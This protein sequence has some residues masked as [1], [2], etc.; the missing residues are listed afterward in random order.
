MAGRSRLAVPSSHSRA[1]ALVTPERWRQIT[2]IFHA[3]LA[4]GTRKRR[5]DF[6]R[7]VSPADPELKRA[8][9]SLIAAHHAAGSFGDTPLSMPPPSLPLER[10]KSLGPYRIDRLIGA[11]G[12]GEVYRAEDPRL[13]RAVA[14]KV[15]PAHSLRSSERLARFQREARTLASL[16]HPHIG[17]LY[18]IEEFNG[19][20]ALVM[21]LVE[22]EDL[23]GRIARGLMPSAEALP[24]ARQIAEALEAAH[25]QGII[26]RDLKP[27]NIK[28]RDD[29]TAK[30]LDFGL[31]KLA[32]LAEAGEEM[33]E[34]DRSKRSGSDLPGATPTDGG[35]ATSE[36]MILGTAAYMSPEQAQGK[37]IDKRTDVWAFGCVLYEMLTGR[38]AFAGST[39]SD[40]INA[41]LEREPD[42]TLLPADTPAPIRTLLRRCL[43][44]DRKRLLDSAAAARLEIDDVL[45]GR[46]GDAGGAS[47]HS[48][49]RVMPWLMAVLAATTVA[50]LV[51]WALTRHVPH[52]PL[53]LSR[54]AIASPGAQPL[55]VSGTDRDL[56]LSPDGR[57][58]VYRF[59]GTNSSGSPLMVRPLDQLDGLR[60]ADVVHAYGPFFS[61][62]SRS[63]GFFETSA[64]KKIS[65]A[66]GP[67]TTLCD[68]TGSSLGAT[69]GADDSIVF[70][71]DD[72]TTGLW[73]IS[74]EG[75]TPTV[76]TTPDAAQHEG[77]H[78]F[79]S[80]LPGGRAVLFTVVAPGQPDQA[81]VAVLDL[82]TR[83]R[84]TLVRGTQAEYVDLSA[85]S[86]EPGFIVYSETG[87]LRAVRFDPIRLEIFGD[88]V[89]LGERVMM[90]GTGASNYALSNVGTLV[91]IPHGTH[92]DTNKP[93]SLVWVDRNG[94]EQPIRAPRRPYGIPRLSPDGTRLAMDIADSNVDIWLWDF[95][96]ETLDRLT[97]DPSVDS[98]AVWTPDGQRIIFMSNRAGVLNLYSQAANGTGAVDRLTTSGTPQ[99]PTSIAPDAMRLVAFDLAG[100]IVLSRVTNLAQRSEHEQSGPAPPARASIEA[101]FKGGFAEISPNGRYVAYQSDESG[102][103]E[104]YVRSFPQVDNGRWQLSTS[105]ATRPAWA[106][107]GRVLFYLDAAGMLT[108]LPVSTSGQTFWA[109]RPTKILDT[110]YPQPNPSRHYD[111]SAD[112]K[113]FLMLKDTPVDDRSATSAS[114]VVVENWFEELKRVMP[115]IH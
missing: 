54:F 48:R 47:T 22:G 100:A 111:V 86:G 17:A 28:V 59:A 31:A 82:R 106:R 51:T 46:V 60:I 14:I 85:G 38:A 30:V 52:A 90:K 95:A 71:T 41:I 98:M 32:S 70:G 3:A 114:M 24:I 36:G 25:E 69:W 84:K 6:L 50:V 108:S 26:H 39:I 99:W 55:N 107:S 42:P 29:G 110:K 67:A 7:D 109:G 64:L 102:R 44:K 97:S 45:S 112:G 105:G 34:S 103:D 12:M 15:L 35:G 94:H 68:V 81:Q 61:A 104:V 11:G 115:Q 37:A 16:N 78:G 73:R 83:R 10:G 93:R 1:R 101:R 4:H 63:I 72:P 8:A 56:A 87:T 23:A 53:R 2:D 20:H 43:E 80:L 13:G 19:E 89:T 49:R 91:Y 40:T 79:P 58:L 27:A 33:T 113:R 96:R 77:D 18:G 75:G 57:H 65:I 9:E 21:E 66:G 5:D 74:A 88:A 92:A 76:L 62:D